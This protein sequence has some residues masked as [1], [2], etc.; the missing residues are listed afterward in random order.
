MYK[1]VIDTDSEKLSSV[2]VY[3]DKDK[4]KRIAAPLSRKSFNHQSRGKGF[5]PLLSHI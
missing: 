4:T 1:F 5:L 3:A 2:N